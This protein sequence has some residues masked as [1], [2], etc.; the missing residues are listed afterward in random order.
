MIKKNRQNLYNRSKLQLEQK[1]QS[2][3]TIRRKLEKLTENSHK[4]NQKKNHRR[5]S[6][7][8]KPNNQS[9]LNNKYNIKTKI[10]DEQLVLLAQR[11]DYD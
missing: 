5:P 10:V 7:N 2:L 11:S 4:K 8:S 9:T 3:T 1:H 6:T